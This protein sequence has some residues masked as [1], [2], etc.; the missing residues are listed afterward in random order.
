MKQ[1]HI[2]VLV[3]FTTSKAIP[4]IDGIFTAGTTGG[5]GFVHT[6][7]K[8]YRILGNSKHWENLKV[9]RR[10][11]PMPDLPSKN[12]TLAIATKK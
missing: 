8:R 12:K 10:K 7:K 3:L 6:R 1:C 4:V 5:A 9:G 11:S 2:L